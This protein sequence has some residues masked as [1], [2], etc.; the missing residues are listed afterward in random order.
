MEKGL[1]FLKI[2]KE[3]ATKPELK[4]ISRRA[5]YA[6]SMM[7]IMLGVSSYQMDKAQAASELSDALNYKNKTGTQIGGNVHNQPNTRAYP[8]NKVP[9]RSAPEQEQ[10][11]EK[12]AFEV[13]TKLLKTIIDQKLQQMDDE[14]LAEVI[15]D[16][17]E[18]TSPI[19]VDTL[20]PLLKEQLDPEQLSQLFVLDEN[21]E[22]L[23]PLDVRITIQISKT[24]QGTWISVL[25]DHRQQYTTNN[26]RISISEFIQY[27]GLRETKVTIIYTGQ[28]G[29]GFQIR[30]GKNDSVGTVINYF[31]T[32]LN[33][34]LGE[35]QY[36]SD[37]PRELENM[38]GMNVQT[39]F[40]FAASLGAK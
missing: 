25:L 18:F 37:R 23:N 15:L 38:T 28:D 10:T 24:S 27:N 34:K 7:G 30:A 17:D 20:F 39:L 32:D 4:K 26:R 11:K 16:S 13:L 2:I 22:L 6:L 33:T 35:M 9:L 36:F 19:S 8:Q 3:K 5:F 1:K 21:G 40:D 12:V 29:Q 14:N 31:P